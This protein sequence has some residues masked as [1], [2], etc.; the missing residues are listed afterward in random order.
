M[1]YEIKKGALSDHS[2]HSNFKVLVSIAV[3]CEEKLA[4]IGYRAWTY[5]L[6]LNFHPQVGSCMFSQSNFTYSGLLFFK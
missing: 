3:I 5:L 4:L 2:D 1:T 6:L